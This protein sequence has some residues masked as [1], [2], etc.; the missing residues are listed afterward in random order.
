MHAYMLCTQG[1]EVFQAQTASKT[2][3]LDWSEGVVEACL[4]G[5]LTLGEEE[6]LGNPLQV[7]ITS[8]AQRFAEAS[9]RLP[10]SQPKIWIA[11]VRADRH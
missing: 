3:L 10:L 9:Q 2:G 8:S 7:A 1:K 6:L 5:C 4:A 11:G